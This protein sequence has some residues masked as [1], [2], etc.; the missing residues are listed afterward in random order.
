MDLELQESGNGG[1]LV[2]KPKDISVIYGFQNMVYLALFGGNVEAS[3]PVTRL[4]NEQAFDYWGNNLF[5]K[6][7]PS[8]QF[9]SETE[10]VLNQVALN[11]SGRITIEESVKRDLQFMTEF[12]KLEIIVSIISVDKVQ[13]LI[14]VIKPNNLE[15]V[16]FI[17]IW[18]S[19]IR[20][21]IGINSSNDS[22]EPSGFRIF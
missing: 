9:N 7:D 18:D 16:E 3:T 21:L 14:N 17:Y 8:V 5:F 13:I 19:T 20:E 10:R 15:S 6:D 22:L 4:E 1:D 11:S 12:A 2:K